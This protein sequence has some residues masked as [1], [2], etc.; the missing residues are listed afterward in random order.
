MN[1]PAPFDARPASEAPAHLQP[2]LD[3][4]DGALAV[5]GTM[6]GPDGSILTAWALFRGNE[7]VGLVLIELPKGTAP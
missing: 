4:V 7:E 5:G 3:C 6:I 1:A 2:Y